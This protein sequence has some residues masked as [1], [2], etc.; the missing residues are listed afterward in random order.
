MNGLEVI[1][2]IC[3]FNSVVSVICSQPGSENIRWKK[4]QKQFINFKTASHSERHDEI[5]RSPTPS[6]S[7]GDSSLCPPYPPCMYHPSN[8]H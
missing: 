4:F 2:I 6:Y 1:P 7:G 8:L 5:S 3:S